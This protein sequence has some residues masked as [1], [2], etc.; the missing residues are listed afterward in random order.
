MNEHEFTLFKEYVA[1]WIK[2]DNDIKE[3]QKKIKVIQ[4]D[5]SKNLMPKII[6]FMK[7]N[8]IAELN[9]ENSGKISLNKTKKRSGITKKNIKTKLFKELDDTVAEKIFKELYDSREVTESFSLKRQ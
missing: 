6:E 1:D 7:K 4:D 9:T 2:K 5:K 8:G 3:L